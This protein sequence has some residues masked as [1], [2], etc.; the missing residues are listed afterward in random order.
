MTK[1]PLASSPVFLGP[2]YREVL[3]PR[4]GLRAFFHSPATPLRAA[5]LAGLSVVFLGGGVDKSRGQE[6][7]QATN[8][9]AT[10]PA[11]GT[12]TSDRLAAFKGMGLAEL[13]D[14]KVTSVKKEPESYGKA[15]AAIEV[16]TGED[17]ER[18][19]ASSIPEA[20]RLADN[21]EVAQIN[22]HDWAISA[23]GFD[24]NLADKLLVLI[25]G[26]AVYTPLYGGVLWNVQ[27][28]LL[29]DLDRIE[30]ISGPGGTLWGANAVNGVINI[31]TKSAQDTQGLYLEAGGGTELQDFTG[32]R[33]GG[34]LASNVYFRVYGKYFDRGS[35]LFTNGNNASDAWSMGQG[36]FRIDAQPSPQNTLTL[37]G[38]GYSGGEDMG[39]AGIEGLDGANLLGRFT[40]AFSQES[41]MSLQLYYDRTFLA[42]PYAAIPGMP[43]ISSGFPAGALTD[44]LDTYDL[45]FQHRFPWGERQKIVWGLGYRFTH[46]VDTDVSLVQF[47][48]PV[49]DQNLYSG[50]VQDEIKLRDDFFLTLGSK[51]EHND[52]TGF[53][54]EPSGRLQWNMTDKQMVWGAVSRAVR[55]PS[56]Y[57]D[58]LYLPT[59]LTL[60]YP[61][62]RFPAAYLVGNPNFVS[63]TLIAYELGY[64]AQLGDKVSVSLS[65]FYNDYNDLRS[66]SPTPTS[67]YY[68]YPLPDVF[69]NNVEGDT[70]GLELSGTYQVLERWRLHA[71]YDLLKEDIHVKPGQV[72]VDGGHFDTADPQ[73][74]FSIRSSMNLTRSVDLDAALRW[75]DELRIAQS[76]T[77]GPTQGTVPSY[78]E[79]DAR[80]GWRVNK[81]IELALVGQ[82]LLHERH[83]EYGY[84]NAS[85]E[86]IARSFYA[87][88]VYR[89]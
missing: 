76:P 79:L 41:E 13:M 17:I 24:A 71:G 27:D 55:T 25:D 57:D 67:T 73:Q 60:S 2:G 16:I 14:Q 3:A 29:E 52:Y 56:R 68:P 72:D 74:Q 87:K 42:Q 10:T 53:E 83:V 12:S 20:L 36:G 59:H 21:L 81:H 78:V 48:P 7:P 34:V 9:P 45:N 39:T 70:Y 4:H 19:G 75:V 64:R 86:E 62:Y 88:A 54:V 82:N 30:V 63:E 89:W 38:D 6:T 61:P 47:L 37:Q 1:E 15:P 28:Y 11:N 49:L 69:G 8:A 44:N 66:T 58:D 65:T 40:H 18:S 85:Q 35:E 22:S 46:E 50:F 80:I 31:T 32:V 23:R 33:Y 77:D 43:R 51:L 5:L 84:P 26:R